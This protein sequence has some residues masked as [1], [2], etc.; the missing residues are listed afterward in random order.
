MQTCI[1]AV[2]A[3]PIMKEVT[4]KKSILWVSFFQARGLDNM[5]LISVLR[6]LAELGRKV[7]L[8]TAQNP[9]KS[10]FK[11]SRIRIISFPLGNMPLFLPVMFTILLF[12]YLPIFSLISKAETIIIE[13]SV[14]VLSVFP[15][16]LMS[17]LRKTLFVLDIRSTPVE[18][19]GFRGSL[20]KFWFAVSVLVAKKKF[21]GITVI[22][23][24]M[25]K[26]VCE[27]YNLNPERVGTWSSGVSQSLFNPEDFTS[28]SLELRRE[29]G[30]SGCFVIFYHGVF[31]PTR[32]L[33][34]VV[35]A[36]KILLPRYPGMVFFL[37]GDGPFAP[38]LKALVKSENLEG[39]VIIA[40]RVDQVEVPQF[41]S[42]C[43]V[44]VVPLPDHPYWRFQSPLKLLEYLAMEKVV[45]V[46][47]IPAHRAVI[48]E[49]KCGI[50]ISS[51]RP[52]EIA[53]AIEYAY[54]NKYSLKDWGK[55]GREIVLREYTWEKV[56]ESLEDYLLSVVELGKK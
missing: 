25:K 17:K 40:K 37:L 53:K 44:A 41:I 39:S 22:T 18:T 14:H 35:S 6:Q 49:A 56:A 16:L 51:I 28:E 2:E 12:F 21:D 27:D 10:G 45:V 30:L 23:P 50:Y 7:S 20:F 31:T 24:L 33:A 3:M 42:M 9:K 38:D 32:G 29:L 43:D 11:E 1:E 54:L 55:I 19:K 52:E 15:L 8:I 36:L 48:G 34:E 47:D 13:P 26:K 4:K 5:S 46:T